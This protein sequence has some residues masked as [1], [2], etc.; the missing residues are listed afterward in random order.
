MSSC[1]TPKT[2]AEI[3]GKT[4]KNLI[5]MVPDGCSVSVLQ[6]ARLYKAYP[7]KPDNTHLSFDSLICGLIKSN[8]GTTVIG[9]S[10]ANVTAMLTGKKAAPA[11]L[12]LDS[13]GEEAI[14]VFETA[15]KQKNKAIGIV[16]TAELCHATLTAS[17]P[18][19]KNRGDYNHI[20][21]HLVYNGADVL[22]AGGG[23]GYINRDFSNKKDKNAAKSLRKDGLDLEKILREEKNTSLY[24]N[25]DDFNK[26]DTTKYNKVWCLFNSETGYL[27]N[28]F[29]RP[30]SIPSLAEMTRKA[31]SVL[32]HNENGFVLLVEGSK[33]DWAAHSN[34]PVGVLSEFLAF[35]KAVEA[36]LEFARSDGNTAV[37]V[38][39]DHGT[40]GMAIGNANSNS[41]GKK[42]YSKLNYNDFGNPLFLNKG[43]IR[44]GEGFRKLLKHKTDSVIT[45][46][47][48]KTIKECPAASYNYLVNYIGAHYSINISRADADT[49]INSAHL[50]DFDFADVFGP[51]YSQYTYI[52]WTTNGHSGEDLFLAIYHPGGYIRKGVIDI[53]EIALY[54][55]DV[56]GLR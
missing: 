16:G 13:L 44:T 29:D 12:G 26:I 14:S 18:H 11:Y 43:K 45:A 2:R 54:I 42:A 52:G 53:T 30:D 48:V 6:L 37:I 21:K 1:K 10:A 20:I 8:T 22:F 50:S 35:E 36:A 4:V 31:I 56:L 40:G 41:G 55:K 33:I 15:R 38:S 19:T 47:H 24:F 17:L 32:K 23:M 9:E 34:D 46:N 3:K 7:D 25:I 39:P 5:I 27:P 51:I 28:D 49:L